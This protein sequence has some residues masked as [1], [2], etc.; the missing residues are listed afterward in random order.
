MIKILITGSTG[1]LGNNLL[2]YLNSNI[3]CEIY[4]INTKNSHQDGVKKNYLWN[5]IMKI[6]KMD[7]FIHLAG[8]S[9]DS[10]DIISKKQFF[11]INFKLTKTIYKKFLKSESSKFIFISSVKAVADSVKDVLTEKCNPNP[12]TFYGKSKLLAERYLIKNMSKKKKLYIL[13]PCM[14]H[15]PGNKGNL[16][17]LFTLISKGIPWPL[18]SFNNKRSFCSIDNLLF[19]INELISSKNISSGVYNI[20]DDQPL[21]TNEII[22]LI[23]KIKNKQPL[24]LNVPKRIIY[25]LAKVGDKIKLPLNSEKLKKLTESYLVSNKKLLDSLGKPLPV[26]SMDGFIK[27]FK[28]FNK[29]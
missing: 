3:S 7:L 6:E 13:R 2:N 11:D 5:E 14:I 27:T 16:K 25:L 23:Y 9:H 18:G 15:G 22:S 21:S 28:S 24:I 12:I 1:F 26:K 19:V 29:F 8:K 20:A 4:T 17:Q 10:N